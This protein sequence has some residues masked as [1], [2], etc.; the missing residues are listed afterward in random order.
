MPFW[1]HLSRLARP[2]SLAFTLL[3]YLLGLAVLRYTGG[4]ISLPLALSGGAWVLLLAVS[5]H[6]WAA[7]F[8]QPFE[9]EQELL[10]AER[11]RLKALLF[12]LNLAALTLLLALLLPLYFAG[13]LGPVLL[14]YLGM[15]LLLLLAYGLPPFRLANR[16]FGELAQAVLIGHIVPAL[17]LLFQQPEL[18][19]LLPL[20]SLPLPFFVLATLLAFNFPSFASDQKYARRTLLVGL[21]WENAIT[22]HNALLLLAFLLLAALGLLGVP[23]RLVWPGLLPLPLAIYQI[24]MFRRIAEGARPE[25]RM[26]N[27]VGGAILALVLYLLAFTLFLD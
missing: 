14:L 8:G 25:W 17:A 13:G 12:N 11:D 15:A 4:D 21:G 3:A 6:W 19:R 1:P 10:P 2:A 20:F 26:T 18:H 9:P 16:G 24:Y 7:Y 23:F 5:Q 22:L 27:L